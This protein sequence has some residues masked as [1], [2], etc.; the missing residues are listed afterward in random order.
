MFAV[1][2]AGVSNAATTTL[3]GE[4]AVKPKNPPAHGAGQS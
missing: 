1:H 3:G 4:A 2:A